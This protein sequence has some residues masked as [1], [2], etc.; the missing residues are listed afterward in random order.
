MLLLLIIGHAPPAWSSNKLLI[1]APGESAFIKLDFNNA[2]DFFIQG[3]ACGKGGEQARQKAAQHVYW[4]KLAEQGFK[5][6]AA[7]AQ[8]TYNNKKKALAPSGSFA[9]LSRQ[10]IEATVSQALQN[11]SM[12]VNTMN[13][14]LESIKQELAGKS[15]AGP[16]N[17]FGVSLEN[18]ALSKND[19]SDGFHLESWEDDGSYQVFVTTDCYSKS[20]LAAMKNAI[21]QSLAQTLTAR[22][23]LLATTTRVHDRQG[24]PYQIR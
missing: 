5:T 8:N 21:E 4:L 2:P 3:W 11:Y 19:P 9:G 23:E 20:E 1:S 14:R 22:E 12:N 15:A 17:F 18:R 6:A 13:A 16:E 24:A 10:E 7:A